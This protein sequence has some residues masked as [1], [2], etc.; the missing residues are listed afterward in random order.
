MKHDT[1]VVLQINFMPITIIEIKKKKNFVASK[2]AWIAGI[3]PSLRTMRMRGLD[4][5]SLGLQE[6]IADWLLSSTDGKIAPLG[7]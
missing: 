1:I 6:Q 7:R 5:L 2:T 4:F 3:P